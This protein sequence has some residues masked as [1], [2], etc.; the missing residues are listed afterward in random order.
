ML[1][2]KLAKIVH[3]INF[4]KQSLKGGLKCEKIK[5]NFF[6]KSPFWSLSVYFMLSGLYVRVSLKKKLSLKKK[7]NP[8][9]PPLTPPPWLFKFFFFF[10]GGTFAC[11]L[12]QNCVTNSFKV[13][14]GYLTIPLFCEKW[15]QPGCAYTYIYKYRP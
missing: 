15:T 10:D 8:P 1:H 11:I 14:W 4:A 13:A 6:F 9:L 5:K 12:Y 2:T 3:I 7:K